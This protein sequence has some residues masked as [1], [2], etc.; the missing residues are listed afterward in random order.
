MAL[1]LQVVN[2]ITLSAYAQQGYAFGRV[3][4]YI[5]MYICI[6]V[7]LYIYM[8]VNKKTGCLVLYRLKIF[9]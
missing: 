9:C 2:I 6:F 4:L 3:R 8:Y 1:I 5:C 7:Y